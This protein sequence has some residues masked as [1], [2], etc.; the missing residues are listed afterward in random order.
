MQ[1]MSI[2]CGFAINHFHMPV[3]RVIRPV[4][5][6][7]LFTAVL[8]LLALMSIAFGLYTH[9]RVPKAFF[10]GLI[11]KANGVAPDCSPDA[12]NI[13]TVRVTQINSLMAMPYCG[14]GFVFGWGLFSVG[15]NSVIILPF[16]IAS[17]VALTICRPTKAYYERI[18]QRVQEWKP[19]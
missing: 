1:F 7:P 15:C 16:A 11:K 9:F 12:N 19:Q 10:K 4:A 3:H 14:S 6:L 5:D 18:G 17:L 2:F 13:L 8:S